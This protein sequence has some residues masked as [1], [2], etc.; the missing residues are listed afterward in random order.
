MSLALLSGDNERE[1]PKFRQLFGESAELRFQQ[2]PLDKLNFVRRLQQSGRTVLMAGDGL[3]DAGALKQADVGVAVVEKTGAF[4]PASDL[5]LESADVP[6]LPD[7]LGFARQTTRVVRWCFIISS[8]YNL[9]GISVAASGLLSPLICAVLMP[10]SSVTVV[11]F[12]TAGAHWAAKR[13]GMIE[14]K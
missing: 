14:N 4:S 3:N 10:I 12:A 5:I 8:F 1:R 6:R 13:H 7:L 9:A 2:S 11:A